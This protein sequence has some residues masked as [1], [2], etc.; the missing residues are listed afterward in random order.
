M[1]IEF[2]GS[3]GAGKSELKKMA[4]KILPELGFQALNSYEARVVCLKRM[5]LGKL[6]EACAPQNWRE[7]IH[8]AVSRRLL[9]LNRVTF[10]IKNYRLMR[11][12]IGQLSLRTIS[13]EEKRM[14]WGFFLRDCSFYK[15]F[16]KHLKQ[17]EA[18]VLSEGLLHRLTSLHSS[19]DEAPNLEEILSYIKIIPKP[20][21]LISVNTSTEKCAERVISRGEYRRYLGKK[22]AHYI[23]NSERTLE[24]ALQGVRQI[25]WNCIEVN[26]D[27]VLQETEVNLH[28]ILSNNFANQCKEKSKVGS[29][30][31]R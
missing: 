18:L 30:V 16:R 17:N 26:N 5:P 11:I 12:A 4:M 23:E 8:S 6:I 2:V 14:I 25:G 19:A 29:S 10:A 9:M 3:P 24:I 28:T 21:L 31:Q 20:D 1:I 13:F 27:T 15:F 22:L 7:K